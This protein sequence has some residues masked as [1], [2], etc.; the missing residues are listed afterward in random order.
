MLM[1]YAWVIVLLDD[2]LSLKKHNNEG[3]TIY[4]K[5]LGLFNI[6]NIFLLFI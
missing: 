1:G 6:D 5:L 2:F 3:K 4:Q